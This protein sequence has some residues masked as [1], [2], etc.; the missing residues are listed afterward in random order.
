[1]TTENLP[2]V[3]QEENTTV[4]FLSS[5]SFDLMQRVAKAFN[6]SSLVPPDYQGTKGFSNCLIA[7]NM[8]TRMKADPLMVMQNLY[9][10]HG[11]PSWSSQFLIATFNSNGRFSALRY[12]FFGEEGTDSWGC[13]AWAVEKETNQKLSGSKITLSLAKSEGWYQKNG[14]K[15]KNMPQQ[16]LMYRAAAW[17]IRAYAPEIAMGLHTQEEMQDVYGDKKPKDI[18]PNNVEDINKKLGLVPDEKPLE[19]EK[20]KKQ[21]EVVTPETNDQWLDDFQGD[22]NV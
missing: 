15:W 5:K 9:V 7:L 16:M 21:E 8:A 10:V 22:K 1:M 4:G 19:E 3:Q 18:T 13:Y 2:V 17:F 12:E 6:S 20:E 14:S 11:R